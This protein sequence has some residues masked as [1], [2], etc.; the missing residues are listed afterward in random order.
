MR[1]HTVK[2]LAGAIPVFLAGLLIMQWQT[3]ELARRQPQAEPA[4]PAAPALPAPA[5]AQPLLDIAPPPSEPALTLPELLP[6]VE[7]A[8][9]SQLE[10]KALNDILDL[11][12]G[13]LLMRIQA[14]AG[15][16][17]EEWKTAEAS[18]RTR[19]EAMLKAAE[20]KDPAAHRQLI[21][22]AEAEHTARIIA[23]LGP[24][25]A[26]K[27]QAAENE[28]RQTIA[29]SVASEA[30]HRISRIIPLDAARRDSL[31]AALHTRAAQEPRNVPAAAYVT[32]AVEIKELPSPPDL[33]KDLDA[34]LTEEQKQVYMM[35]RNA[36]NF[37]FNTL[38]K[39]ISETMIPAIKTVIVDMVDKDNGK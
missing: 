9:L 38:L 16:S 6:A 20:T 7:Q 17:E 19:R 15:M 22:Q 34:V 23:L 33:S 18:A 30:L 10:P 36:Q 3:R 24:E 25:R 37:Q 11:Q 28:H 35:N 29:E 14:L 1:Y 21:D 13:L 5:K 2:M 8:I 31:Y 4:S 39:V 12:D 32:G 27:W 26:A